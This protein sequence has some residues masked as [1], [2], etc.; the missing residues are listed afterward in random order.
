MLPIP[1]F[2]P[3]VRCVGELIFSVDVSS[4]STYHID[5]GAK[6]TLVFVGLHKNGTECAIKRMQ[7][8]QASRNIIQVGGCDIQ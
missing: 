4:N 3:Q 8:L 7:R 5:H 2:L 1:P 6:G